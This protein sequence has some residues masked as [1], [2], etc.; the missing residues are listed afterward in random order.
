LPDGLSRVASLE[1]LNDEERSF[2]S[3]VQGRTYANL[4]GLVERYINAN[5]L[6]LARPFLIASDLEVGVDASPGPGS[7]Q[8]SYALATALVVEACERLAELGAQHVVLVTFHGSPLHSLALQEGEKLLAKR[9]VR[10]LSPLNLLL[11]G[12]LDLDLSPFAD[13]YATRNCASGAP[14]ECGL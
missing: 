14:G 9:G 3:G 2:A 10:A 12:M 8:T 5:V 11:K 7:R 1:F 4:F 6:E 13:A